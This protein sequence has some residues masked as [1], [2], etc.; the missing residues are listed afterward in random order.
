[1]RFIKNCQSKEHKNRDELSTEEIKEAEN[2]LIQQTQTSF[3]QSRLD[4]LKEQLGNFVDIDGII[5]CKGRLSKSSLDY[6]AKYPILLPRESHFTKLFILQC[7]EDV[8]HNG[9]KETLAQLRSRFWVVRGR[10]AVKKL[11]RPCGTCRRIQGHSYR[12][13]IKGRLPEFCSQEEHAFKSVGI[14]FAG[15]LYVKTSS[16]P[17]RKVY[18]ALFTCSTSRAVHLEIVPDLTADSFLLCL[19]RFIGRRGIPC[20][21]VSD[22]AKTFKAAAKILVKLFKSSKISAYLA[23]QGIKGQFNL[24]KAPLWGGFLERLVR[25]VKS[26][27]KKCVGNAKFS[28]DKFTTVII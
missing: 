3:K 6:E 19:R 28:Y 15:L 13:P 5:R 24:A 26:S 18:I 1:M 21:I 10:Q 25:S 4:E 16:N 27:L 20:L 17:A 8:M 23:K 14:D 2:I 7:H 12:E 22:N 11:I 9:I